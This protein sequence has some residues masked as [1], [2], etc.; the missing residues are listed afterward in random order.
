MGFMKSLP[1]IVLTAFLVVHAL[2]VHGFSR[3]EE[4]PPHRPL[5]EFPAEFGNWTLNHRGVVSEEVQAV[6][7]ADDNMVCS[8]RNTQGL[9]PASLYVAYFKTQRTGVNPH[10]PKHCLPGSGWVPTVSDKIEFPVPGRREP[11]G[12]NRYLVA[13]GDR[14]SLILVLVPD[15]QPG[16]R[17]RVLGQVLPG[18]RCHSLQSHGHGPGADQRPSLAERRGGRRHRDPIRP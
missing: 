1:A 11:I 8:Y 16:Y 15:S 7:L 6:L 4:T 10:S 13:K 3:V 2:V 17:E 14:K 9:A 5:A 12:V 18:S